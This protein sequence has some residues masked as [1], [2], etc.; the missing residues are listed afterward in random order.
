MGSGSGGSLGVWVVG[1]YCNAV[2]VDNVRD[3]SRRS[4]MTNASLPWSCQE[5]RDYDLFEWISDR[6][7]WRQIGKERHTNARRAQLQLGKIPTMK[8]LPSPHD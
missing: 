3:G 8:L 6:W 1:F 2:V 7:E 4:E 5:C